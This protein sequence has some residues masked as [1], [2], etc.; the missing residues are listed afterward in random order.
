MRDFYLLVSSLD[1]HQYFPDNKL[2]C[3][4]VKLQHPIILEGNGWNIGLCEVSGKLWDVGNDD[5]VY[6]FC[7]LTTGLLLPSNTEGLLRPMT[8]ERIANTYAQYTPVIYTPIQTH[9]IDVIELSLK[10][11]SFQNPLRESNGDIKSKN[12]AK[13][14]TTCLLHFKRIQ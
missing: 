6:I 5:T 14:C 12:N 11:N 9:F 4:H 13:G 3:F 1:S 10:V 7:N 8:I 2:G